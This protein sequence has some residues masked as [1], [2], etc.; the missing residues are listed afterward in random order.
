MKEGNWSSSWI[1]S[2][3]PSKQRSYTRFAPHHVKGGLLGSHLAKPLAEKLKTRSLRVRKG[4]TVKVMRGQYAG[5][6]GK[7]NRI[8]VE[9]MRVFI[10]GVEFPKR[11]GSKGLYPLHPS[12]IMITDLEGKDKRRLAESVKKVSQ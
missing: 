5:K 8:D 6:S 4:D 3:K 12:K 2:K 7:V 10:D 9:N 1:G 11:D